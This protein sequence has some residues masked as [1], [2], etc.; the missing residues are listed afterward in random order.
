MIAAVTP[1]DASDDAVAWLDH[2]ASHDLAISDW[3]RVEIASAL[4]MKIRVGHLDTGHRNAIQTVL[5]EWLEDTLDVLP[6]ER[7]TFAEARW[8]I[9]SSRRGLRSGDALHLALA[10]SITA[11][12]VTL[13]R[14][15]AAEARDAGLDVVVPG[16]D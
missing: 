6:L 4:A 11:G 3:T 9:E 15:L 8:F 2:H 12:L 10:R 1:E 5:D 14:T 13:D 16:E 7:E